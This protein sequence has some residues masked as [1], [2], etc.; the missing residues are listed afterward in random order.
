MQ[1]LPKFNR[2]EDLVNLPASLTGEILNGQLYAQPRPS[3]KHILA[4]SNIGSEIHGAYQ[5][6]R[7][8]PGGWWILQEPEVHF[9]LDEEVTVPDVAGWRKTTMPAIPD[10]HKFTIVPDWICEIH[11]PSTESIDR[12]IKKPL[13]ARFGVSFL[14]LIH[15]KNRTLETYRLVEGNWKSQ[16]VYSGA[17]TFCVEPF[18]SVKI[19][20]DELLS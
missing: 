7:G 16:G 18:E 3:G 20:L 17:D 8:G 2:Y 10:G 19:Q 4:A 13:Y 12:N 11:S 14:W 9:V 15:P 6:G 1:M 5:R